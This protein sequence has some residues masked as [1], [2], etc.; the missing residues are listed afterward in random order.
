V[1]DFIR[2]NLGIEISVDLIASMVGMTSSMFY[3]AYKS[4][5]KRL[6]SERIDELR[7]A[8]ARELLIGRRDLS[9]HEIGLMLGYGGEQL[10]RTSFKKKLGIDPE[11][12]RGR[13]PKSKPI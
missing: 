1:D 10:L 3:M 4:S 11:F 12:F 13:D 6:V 8:R 7:T 5:A 2:C 9:V